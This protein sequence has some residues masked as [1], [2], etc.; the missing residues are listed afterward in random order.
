LELTHACWT[1]HCRPKRKVSIWQFRFFSFIPSLQISC[2]CMSC[3]SD[4]KAHFRRVVKRIES[5]CGH[6]SESTHTSKTYLCIASNRHLLVHAT[7]F[8]RLGLVELSDFSYHNDREAF[9]K[10]QAGNGWID[11]GIEYCSIGHLAGLFNFGPISRLCIVGSLP[12][13]KL[14][15]HQF[16]PNKVRSKNPLENHPTLATLDQKKRR[17]IPRHLVEILESECPQAETLS[18]MLHDTVDNAPA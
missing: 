14:F 5:S 4:R 6:F 15:F 18:Q 12:S 11:F 3:K 10:N 9:V 7:T 13:Q 2:I 16:A 1:F 17:S 8:A